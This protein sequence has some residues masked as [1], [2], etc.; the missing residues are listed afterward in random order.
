M[1][2]RRFAMNYGAVL[3]LILVITAFLFWGFGIDKESPIP[4]II[5][6]ILV[7]GFIFY[8]ITEYRNNINYGLI[9]YRDSLKLGTTVA[10]FSSVIM[11][12]YTFIYI[13]YLDPDMLSDIL[14]RTEQNVLH[15]QPDISDEQLDLALEMTAKFMQPHW[16]MIWGVLGGT[17]IGFFYSA[18]I[19]F[20]VRRT[21]SNKIA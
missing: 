20:F 6:N 14:N 18:I 16:L 15:S 5:N 4:S 7:I 9:S 2:K 21:D 17:F 1:D 12:F 8:S 11:A 19:A 13:S 10:F 3:G